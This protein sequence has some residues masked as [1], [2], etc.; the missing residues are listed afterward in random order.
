MY[1][2]KGNGLSA[3]K[4]VVGGGAGIAALEEVA[5]FRGRWVG[6]GSVPLANAIIFLNLS[7]L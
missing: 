4:A 1:Q 3:R 5:K 6:L 7:I 2:L